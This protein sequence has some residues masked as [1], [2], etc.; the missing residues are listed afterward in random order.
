MAWGCLL[1]T[2][3]MYKVLALMLGMKRSGH[4]LSIRGA[5]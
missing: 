2:L 1:G 4:G 3:I 5:F